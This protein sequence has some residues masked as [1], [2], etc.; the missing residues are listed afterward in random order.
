[1]SQVIH[2]TNYHLAFNVK[3]RKQVLIGDIATKA[4]EVIQNIASKNNCEIQEIQVMPDHIHLLISIP[5]QLGIA[6]IVKQL[7]GSSSRFL[8][9]E[10]PQLKIKLRK[11]HLWSS[12]YFIR[13]TGNVTMGTI[14][15]YIQNQK[16]DG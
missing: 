14:K 13:T 1:M 6:G 7:K 11:G 3:Y 5:P 16:K 2:K 4:K 8:V 9:Q 15:K 12:S 10:F